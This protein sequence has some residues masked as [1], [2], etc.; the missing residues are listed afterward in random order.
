MKWGWFNPGAY[1]RTDDDFRWLADAE[2]N[3][4][5]VAGEAKAAW[6]LR[7]WGVR[8][9]RAG[10]AS[11]RVDRR[12]QAFGKAGIGTGWANQYDLWVIYAIA[13]GWA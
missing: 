8:H 12:A 13:R 7:L 11:M 4:W 2:E 3:G 10:I 1:I 9:V 5:A 6:P